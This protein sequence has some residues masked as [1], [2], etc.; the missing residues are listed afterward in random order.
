MNSE[1]ICDYCDEEYS[2]EIIENKIDNKLVN[3]DSV[4][5]N[6]SKIFSIIFPSVNNYYFAKWDQLV[7]DNKLILKRFLSNPD[8][9][10]FFDFV[11]KKNYYENIEKTLSKSL[12]N[13]KKIV[14]Y[15]EFLLS[16]F[17]LISP[18]DIRVVIIGQDPYPGSYIHNKK[19]IPY[20]TGL[21][22]SVPIGS[23]IPTSLQNI[24]KNL[25]KFN[26]ISKKYNCDCLSGWAIQGCFMINSSLTTIATQKKAH[27]NIWKYFTHDLIYY[28]DKYYNNIAFIVWGADAHR[29]CQSIDIKKHYISTSSHPSSL[30]C[31]KTF[32]GKEYGQIKNEQDRKKVKYNSFESVD[33]FGNVN[34]YLASTNSPQIIW[35]LI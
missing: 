18:N 27:S 11:S 4:I 24:E 22:F 16:S 32:M 14:P 29:I 26:H 15:P 10:D 5:I 31:S 9:N 33:H 1:E 17:N 34:K 12:E 20:A 25:R 35:D 7:P 28:L 19:S 13:N 23:K 3:D 6:Q 8:W 2:D 30:S 21:S